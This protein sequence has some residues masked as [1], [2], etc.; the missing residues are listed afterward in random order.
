MV[1][2]VSRQ[3]RT[4]AKDNPNLRQNYESRT[5]AMAEI[6]SVV[7]SGVSVA[8]L[9][10]QILKVGIKIK[11][12][13]DEISD[14]PEMLSFLVCQIEILAPVL[15]ELDN[16]SQF[17]PAISG[18]LRGSIQAAIAQCEKALA[19]LESLSVDLSAQIQA[20]RGLKRRLLAAKVP[21]KKD[22]L[23]RHERRLSMSV[24]LLSLAQQT[25]MMYVIEIVNMMRLH[26]LT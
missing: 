2:T 1:P 14:A 5:T 24:Q 11:G 10:G 4:N 21:L 25:Y 13:L 19:Y 15:C 8:Q 9:A 7:A 20:S 6:L 23:M 17:S 12:F 16:M 3:R 22:E 18:S 26:G